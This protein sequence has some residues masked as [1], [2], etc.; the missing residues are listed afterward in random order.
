MLLPLSHQT[1]LFPAVTAHGLVS[2]ASVWSATSAP[3][4]DVNVDQLIKS[5]FRS[6]AMQDDDYSIGLLPT[7]H[8]L[9]HKPDMNS[10]ILLGKQFLRC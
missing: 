9:V 6:E 8:S 4:V 3:A 1:F 5:F 10:V 2:V 7:L